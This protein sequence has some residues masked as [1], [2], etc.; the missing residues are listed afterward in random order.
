VDSSGGAGQASANKPS[1]PRFDGKLI[2][3]KISNYTK[4]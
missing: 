3:E 1:P 4:Q 2:I